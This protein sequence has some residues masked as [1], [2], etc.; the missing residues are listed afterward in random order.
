MNEALQPW[1]V[2]LISDD[3]APR[4]RTAIADALLAALKKSMFDPKHQLHQRTFGYYQQQKV[5]EI[6]KFANLRI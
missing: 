1:F 6:Q 2:M 3:P 4:P 5:K